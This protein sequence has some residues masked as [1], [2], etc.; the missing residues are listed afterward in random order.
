MV[1]LVYRNASDAFCGQLSRIV[2]R[3]SLVDPRGHVTRELVGEAFTIQFPRERFITVPY[4]QNNPFAAIVETVWMLSGRD[5][6]A[7]LLPYLPRAADF[8]DDGQT[9]R[10]AYGPRLRDWKGTDQVGEVLRLLGADASS[11]RGVMSIFDPE[12]DFGESKDIPCNNWLHWMVRE[13]CLDLSIAVRSNDIVW[14]FSG[15]N[16]FEWSVLH[17]CMARWLGVSV[18]RQHWLVSSMHL[19]ERHRERTE[20]IL[21][22]WS[23][24]LNLYA[25]PRRMVNFV[26][27][28]DE[29]DR[30]LTGWFELETTIRK[31]PVNVSDVLLSQCDDPLLHGFLV[32]LR[33]YWLFQTGEAEETVLRSLGELD[34]TDLHAAAC[35]WLGRHYARD[36][37]PPVR[38]ADSIEVDPIE[39]WSCELNVFIARLHRDKDASYHDSWKKR[40]EQISILANIARKVDRLE[41]IAEGGSEGSEPLFETAVDAFVYGLKYCT[42]LLDLDAALRREVLG[43]TWPQAPASDGTEGF[44]RLLAGYDPSAEACG[45]ALDLCRD[46]TLALSLAEGLATKGA[47]VR[48][49]LEVAQRLSDVSYQLTVHWAPS[50]LLEGRS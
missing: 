34:G 25:A 39:S 45:D 10:A 26:T 32:M 22:A 31:S 44:D 19:Y 18:G 5:D 49:R 17:E 41:N 7:F 38:P 11:R 48:D 33:A 47:S 4:R 36:A 50:S 9:W 43:D 14:G 1:Q 35:F 23:R 28:F 30:C 8:S 42:Y 12:L 46:L 3:G 6:V 24:Q 29:F 2:A 21:G 13:G 37:V 40:G 15:I 16:T 27:P 20:R